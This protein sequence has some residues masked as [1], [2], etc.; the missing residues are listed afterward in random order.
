MANKF[1]RTI[2]TFEAK[3]YQLEKKDGEVKPA[4]I[5]KVVYSAA[6]EAESHARKA[7]KENGIYVPRGCKVIIDCIGT[8]KYA[9]SV[10]EFMQYAH[11]VED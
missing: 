2:K 9:L 3:A 8:K 6:S 7:F 5:A 4:V 1:T 10:D 11:E